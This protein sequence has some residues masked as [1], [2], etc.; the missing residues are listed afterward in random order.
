[1]GY[2]LRGGGAVADVGGAEFHGGNL[3]RLVTPWAEGLGQKW[4]TGARC[5]CTRSYTNYSCLD[6]LLPTVPRRQPCRLVFTHHQIELRLRFLLLQCAQSVN[7]VSGAATFYL[8]LVHHYTGDIAKGQL[9]HCQPVSG[10]TE[11]AAFVPGVARREYIQHVQMQ[12]CQ[13]GTHQRHMHSVR[14]IKCAAEYANP[15][16]R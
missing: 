3:Q 10:W 15:A 9:G 5:F 6:N 14:W 12:L 11:R 4:A 2:S 7:G 1:M 13:G 8:A 16:Q